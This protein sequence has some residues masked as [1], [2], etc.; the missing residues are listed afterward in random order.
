[1]IAIRFIL[2]QIIFVLTSCSNSEEMD[3]P[4]DNPTPIVD[5][6]TYIPSTNT[7]GVLKKSSDV[8]D[9]YTLFSSNKSTFLINNCGQ[10]INKW[11]SNYSRGN[12]V[13]LTNDGSILRAG[14]IENDYISIG[15]IGGIIERFDWNGNLKWSYKYSSSQFSHH[16]DL[17]P[18]PNGNILLLVLQIKTKDEAI[19][20]GRDPLLIEENE[21][22]T[23]QVIE[24][25]PKGTNQADIVWLW[26]AWDHLIQDF[27]ASKSNY[28]NVKANPQLLNLNY[29]TISGLGKK[30]WLHF[31]SLNY[32]SDLDQ[33]LMSS[34]SLNEIYIIDHSTSAEEVKTHSGGNSN[35]G[36][37][38][39]Y[40]W[41]NPATYN[42]GDVNDKKLFGPHFPNW[43]N[44]GVDQGKIIIF[45]NGLNRSD[46]FSS[47]DIISPPLE[48]STT[49]TT[50]EF[51]Q[52]FLPNNLH[53]QYIDP[54]NPLNFFSK[55]ISGAQRLPNDNT[56]ICEGT[57]GHLFEINNKKQIVWEYINPDSANGTLTQGNSP[58]ANSVFRAIKYSPEH[59]GLKNKN[60]TPKSPIEL[61]FDLGNCK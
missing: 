52:N 59:P 5:I 22:Y 34:Q 46:N 28:G 60:L 51:G 12:A 43:I 21:L 13:Y 48:T 39:L 17:Y 9:G 37:D 30:D 57:K 18:L 31:N 53:W 29:T 44:Y 54:I 15:G 8:Y 47:V 32:N 40:R 3:T 42:S 25:I 1:M 11:S 36:G 7:I 56:L 4:E 27:D 55:I 45:N 33:I 16:H 10:I 58:T 38:F 20:A 49:Y 6:E 2:L 19:A 26:D 50:P 14:K 41:G 61:N 23:E 24:I 35:K